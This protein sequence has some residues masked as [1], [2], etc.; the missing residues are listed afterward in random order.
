MTGVR[1]VSA[2]VRLRP[3][4]EADVVALAA[5]LPDDYDLDPTIEAPTRALHLLRTYWRDQAAWSDGSWVLHLVATTPEG[6]PIGM[7][8]MEGDDFADSRTVDSASW[9]AV[10]ERNRGFGGAMRSGM[11]ALAFDGLG[12][13]TAVTSAWRDNAASLAVS[14]RLGYTEDR[15]ERR[16]R[17]DADD[18]LVHLRLDA[19]T[20]RASRRPGVTLSGIDPALPSFGI[21]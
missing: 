13:R 12:A 21:A 8:T 9:V 2:D 5:V 6:R 3:A 7:Q 20:W 19:V 15:I 16:P 17:G 4:T 14:R 1:I 18:D 10:A 11:L